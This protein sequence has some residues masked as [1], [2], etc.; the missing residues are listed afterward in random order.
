MTTHQLRLSDARPFFA[1]LPYYLW[2]Q[3]NYDS[4]GDCRSPTDRAWTWL[5]LRNRETGERLEV[6]EREGVWEVVGDDP[7]AARAA[8]FMASRC[9]GEWVGSLPAGQLQGWD[10]ERAASRAARVREEFERP[11]LKPFDAGHLFWGSWKWVGWCG[12]EFTWVGRWIMDSV[13]RKDGR[14]VSLCV[15]WL[16]KGTIAEPQSQALRYALHV[17]T[18]RDFPTDKKWVE[19][20]DRGG[21]Y[22]SIPSPTPTGGMRSC[23]RET[24]SDDR[25]PRRHRPVRPVNRKC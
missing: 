23:G 18:G 21:G 7:L 12:T 3:V 19:W 24:P 9:R 10:H 1:E 15:E 20:Y 8:L 4:G 2:G 25:R 14:A 16:R 22:G 17:L 13:I 11:E 5:K 6:A